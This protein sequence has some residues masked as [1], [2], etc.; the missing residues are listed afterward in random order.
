M[1]I[2]LLQLLAASQKEPEG[3]AQAVPLQDVQS[4]R[5][6]VAHLP[7]LHSQVVQSP[8]PAQ[9]PPGM[10]STVQNPYWHCPSAQS[11]PVAQ[12]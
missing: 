8:F 12:K 5:V 3:A 4:A 10:L 2:L 6:Q 1:H 9:E 7:L 11:L